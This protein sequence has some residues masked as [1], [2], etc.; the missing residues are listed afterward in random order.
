M[1]HVGANMTTAWCNSLLI[2]F[3]KVRKHLHSMP[4]MFS[5]NHAHNNTVILFNS[6]LHSSVSSDRYLFVIFFDLLTS[7]YLQERE[8]KVQ[9]K[10][11]I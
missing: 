9:I 8:V 10:F 6:I 4:F 5:L 11:S 7:T 3:G 1:R 2:N